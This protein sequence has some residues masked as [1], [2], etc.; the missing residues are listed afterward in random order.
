MHLYSIVAQE[1]GYGVPLAFMIME[2]HPKEKTD[3]DKHKG[4]ALECSSHFYRKAKELG[5][6]P[7]FVHTDKDWSEIS[8]VRLPEEEGLSVSEQFEM[9]IFLAA[10]FQ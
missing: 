7:K 10:D 4:E 6:D 9:G 5:I 8:A 2:I 1:L 3:T